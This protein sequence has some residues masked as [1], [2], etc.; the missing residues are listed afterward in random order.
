[1]YYKLTIDLIRLDT[2]VKQSEHAGMVLTRGRLIEDV[3]SYPLKYNL[4][5]GEPFVEFDIEDESID[6][7]EM[8]E[9]SEGSGRFAYYP[10]ECLM[11]NEMVDVIK[12]SG[13]DNIQIFPAIIQNGETGEVIDNYLAVN[14]LGLIS[15]ANMEESEYNPLGDANYFHDLVVNEDNIHGLKMFRLAEYPPDIIVHK[16]VANAIS[17]SNFNGVVLQELKSTVN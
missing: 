4:T 13:V 15:C 8:I 16:D 17:K 14:I 9:Q 1:M 11:T 6:F 10:N 2:T 12:N 7:D 3:I 5:K